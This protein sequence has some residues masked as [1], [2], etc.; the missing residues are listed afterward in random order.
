MFEAAL[1]YKKTKSR[2]IIILKHNSYIFYARVTYF[3]F[4]MDFLFSLAKKEK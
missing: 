2:S 4:R 1:S 3:I